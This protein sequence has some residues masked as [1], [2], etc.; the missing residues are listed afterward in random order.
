VSAL[1]GRLVAFNALRG[2]VQIADEGDRNDGGVAIRG[3]QRVRTGAVVADGGRDNAGER[4]DLVDNA[5]D[6]GPEVRIVNGRSPR[7]PFS[8]SSSPLTESGRLVK[9][10][11]VV[12]AS[13]SDG[14]RSPAATSSTTQN[15]MTF[16][17][18][19]ALKR[20]SPAVD[21]FD[22]IRS[23]APQLVVTIRQSSPRFL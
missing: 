2:L 4:R 1:D 23:T 18:C 19:C 5:L 20:A 11:S 13:P 14:A 7:S 17:G 3:D 9:P 8:S 16:Q 22:F 15:S 21:T 6:R 10:T 12:S